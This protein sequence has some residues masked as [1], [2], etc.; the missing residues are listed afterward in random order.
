MKRN[1]SILKVIHKKQI[2]FAAAFFLLAIFQFKKSDPYHPTVKDYKLMQKS[3][4]KKMAPFIEELGDFQSRCQ[5]KLVGKSKSEIPQQGLVAV[6]CAESDKENCVILYAT[7]NKN[8]AAG[9]KRLVEH[10][11]KSDFKGHILYRIGG[12]PNT[13]G[14]DFALAYVPYAFK[15]CF[16]R[17]A[18]RLG[19][20]RALWLDTS[21]LPLASLNILF[22]KLQEQ[23]YLAMGNHFMVGPFFNEKASPFFKISFQ[24]TFQI[25][26]CSSGIFGLDF[27]HEKALKALSLWYEAARDPTAYYSARPDQNALSLILYALEM[28]NWL[29]IETLAHGKNNINNNSLFLI[30]RE[31]VQ[32]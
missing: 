2:F 26:S 1:F 10:I 5:I 3:M 11:A 20:K 8:Y 27:S 28:K 14:G 15:V 25:P 4:K 6:N 16:F 9:L 17:E 24:D 7:Y 23:G 30:E 13:E 29:S 19:Y 12:W 18:Q 32:D 21:I 31:F 22:K